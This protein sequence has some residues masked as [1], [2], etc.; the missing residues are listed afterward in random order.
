[1][2]RFGGAYKLRLA[3]LER[4][5]LQL[6]PRPPKPN[7]AEQSSPTKG[8]IPRGSGHGSPS[9]K[10]KPKRKPK[11]TLAG[12]G[13]A[14]SPRVAAPRFKVILVPAP[15]PPTLVLPAVLRPTCCAVGCAGTGSAA[16][17][18]EHVLVCG[19]CGTRWQSSWWFRY[20]TAAASEEAVAPAAA[21]P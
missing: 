17:D 10:P 8:Q 13:A 19:A 21:P 1:M 12:S 5:C 6:V 2:P 9:A 15:P 16:E 18:A 3:C 14:V 4:K 20:L 11:A 7:A